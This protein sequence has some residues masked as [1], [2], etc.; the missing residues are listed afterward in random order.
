M[1]RYVTPSGIILDGEG[2]KPDYDVALEMEVI[3]WDNIDP[4]LDTQL[5]KALEVAQASVNVE[6]AAQ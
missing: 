1:A 5:K 4:E 3:D 6:T 2:V